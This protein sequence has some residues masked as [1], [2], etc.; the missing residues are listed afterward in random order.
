MNR[1]RCDICGEEIPGEDLHRSSVKPVRFC[2]ECESGVR[3][4]LLP[5]SANRAGEGLYRHSMKDEREGLYQYSEE[6]EREGL[7]D[8][9]IDDD[10]E[11]LY[12]PDA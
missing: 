8:A 5:H 12:D 4:G 2:R 1:I 6:D 10:R 9:S 3:H 11:G 7:F